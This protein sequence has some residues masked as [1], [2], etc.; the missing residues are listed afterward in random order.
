[1]EIDGLKQLC[2]EINE[3]KKEHNLLKD[4]AAE[5]YKVVKEKSKK[6]LDILEAHE[7]QNFDTGAG[8][9]IKV[10][11][12]SVGIADKNAFYAWLKEH[13]W[14]EDT[15]TI[16]AA[17]ATKIYNEEFADAQERKDSSF[18]REGIPGLTEPSNFIDIQM[19]GFK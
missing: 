8:K 17:T 7:L 4:K 13:G 11:K 12:R 18:L 2:F 15:V 10:T 9:I 6:A 5:V 16:S 1:M 19:R 14:F 3:A